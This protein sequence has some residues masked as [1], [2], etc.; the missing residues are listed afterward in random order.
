MKQV[1]GI[2]LDKN[3]LGLTGY[4]EFPYASFFLTFALGFKV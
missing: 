4:P 1:G 2:F 3:A